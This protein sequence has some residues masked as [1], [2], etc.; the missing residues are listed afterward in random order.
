MIQNTINLRPMR[1]V[2]L[3]DAAFRLYRRNFWTFVGIM[4]LMQVPISLLTLG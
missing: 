2:E 1:L 3:L 4:A